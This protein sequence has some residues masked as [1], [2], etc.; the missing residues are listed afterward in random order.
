MLRRLISI[1]DSC[2][3]LRRRRL[4]I[5]IGCHY[6]DVQRI[7]HPIRYGIVDENLLQTTMVGMILY[8]ISM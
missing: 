7:A 4:Q 3:Q 5:T 8:S 1:A 2:G 6:E